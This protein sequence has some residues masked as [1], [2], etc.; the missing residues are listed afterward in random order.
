MRR[1]STWAWTVL[2]TLLL[3]TN[4]AALNPVTWSGPLRP[5]EAHPGGTVVLCIRATIED[6]YHLYSMTTPPGGPIRTRIGIKAPPGVI[7]TAAYQPEPFRKLDPTFN[8]DVETFSREADFF[9]SLNL[10]RSLSEG[11]HLVEVVVRYQACSNELCL[12]PVER[13]VETTILVRFGALSSA[14]VPAG[15]QRVDLLL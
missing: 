3:S 8:V 7:A 1:T 5:I 15:Y 4:A 10:D 11:N 13:R 2:A 9:L 12:A 14:K 6:G